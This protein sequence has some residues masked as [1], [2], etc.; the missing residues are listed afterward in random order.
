MLLQQECFE[1]GL[2]RG[3][4]LL[5]RRLILVRG[6]QRPTVARRDGVHR[7]GIE[8]RQQVR[9]S[10]FNSVA[11]DERKL[12]KRRLGVTLECMRGRLPLGDVRFQSQGRGGHSVDVGSQLSQRLD[13]PSICF[14]GRRHLA[15]LVSVGVRPL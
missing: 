9:V 4:D 6:K 5:Q 14:F 3:D 13:K 8:D 10:L 2:G 7:I 11:I 1:L 15:A 12:S